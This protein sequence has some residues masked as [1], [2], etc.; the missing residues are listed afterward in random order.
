MKLEKGQVIKNYKELCKL[1]GV[2]VK[3]GKGKQYQ[4]REIERYYKF[5]KEGYKFIVEEVYSEPKEK[6]DNRVNNGGNNTKYEDLMDKIIINTLIEYGYIEESFSEIMNILDF[7]KPKYIDL[8]KAGYKKFAEINNLGVGF[9]LTYQQKL[10]NVVKKCLETSLNR[11]DKNGIITYEKRINV[12]D[13]NFNEYLADTKMEKLINKYE[14]ETYEEMGIKYYNR[15]LTDVNRRFKNMVSD[16]LDIMSYWNV[17]CFELVDKNIKPVDE[18]I[19]ELKRRLIQSVI[20]AVKNKK[21]K[22]EFG[23]V[24][25]PYSY[26]K[27]DEQIDKLTKLLWKLPKDYISQ[28]DFELLMVEKTGYFGQP[29]PFD[30]RN[31]TKH[32]TTV[33]CKD[34]ETIDC[35]IDI[36][37]YNEF[38]Q[39]N[40]ENINNIPF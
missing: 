28:S 6:I 25:Y 32:D 34:I 16:K 2:E 10:N 23:N 33:N 31:I 20:D 22:D 11:L 29:N 12:R 36:D 21:S 40:K 3:G 38:Y 24:F 39:V 1:L 26:E 8:N 19:D 15:I 5:R 4:M 18:D 27:Y 14:K 13:K 37:D 17:Y 35:D 9:T 30:K 7:F